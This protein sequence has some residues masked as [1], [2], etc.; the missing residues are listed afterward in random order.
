TDDVLAVAYQYSYRGKIFQVGEFSE[1]LPPDTTS[2]NQKI[3]YLKLLKATSQRPNL[4]IW[5]LMLKNV[6]A[7]GYGSLTPTDFKLDVLYQEPGLGWKRYVP[8]GDKNQGA[9]IISLI[10]LDRLNNQ[11]DP[12]PDGVFD[13]V[14]GYTVYSQYSRVMFPVLEPF[15]RDLAV[16]IYNNPANPNIKDTLFYALYDSIKAKAQQY[17]NLNRFVLKGSAKISGSS[18]ISIGYNI[19]RGSVTVTAG[20]RV[21][22]EGVDYDINY[23][24][25]TIKIINTAIINSGLPVQVN[26]ENNASFGLQQ[27][28]YIGLRADYMVKNN[29]KEQLAVG[30]TMVRLGERPFFSKVSYDNSGVGG[31]NEPIRNTM[32]GADVNWRRDMPRLTKIL[33]KLPFYKANGPSSL[34][35]FAEVAH[36][37]PGHAPQIGKGSNGIINIDDFDGTKSGIDLR[38]PPIAWALASIPE[39]ATDINGNVLFP[40]AALNDNIDIGKKRA[41]IAWYQIEPVLQQY[42]GSNNPFAND[43][44]QLSDPRVRQVYQKEI[45]PQKTTGFGESQLVTFDL[46]YYPDQKGPYNYDANPLTVD[47][48]GRLKNPTKNWGGLMRS[49]DQTDFETAN[50]EFIEFWLQDPFIKYTQNPNIVNSNGGKLYFDLGNV[51]ED[52]LKDG[53]R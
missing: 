32:Y 36:F 44:E 42:K 13:Y 25:G 24:L 53:K 35:V 26:Y 43:R 33:D 30:A 29:K 14:E 19:P 21:L 1:D 7:I 15:G 11:G 52:I 22:L 46:A 6:Y 34:T 3:L 5:D 41:K 8:F 16:N 10:N 50:I 45:F 2:G 40:E 20:G 18:D 39:G 51:S 31:T 23:D 4:P 17:P 28:N 37:K 27:K 9:P 48:A 38:F 12:Q 49:I 47:A